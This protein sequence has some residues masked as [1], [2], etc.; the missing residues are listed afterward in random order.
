MFPLLVLLYAL[1]P[2]FRVF[3]KAR[4]VPGCFA[5]QIDGAHSEEVA[6]DD[7][8]GISVGLSA[9]AGNPTATC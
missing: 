4:D 1:S 9:A 3:I 5:S 7:S 2:S 6:A 8:A